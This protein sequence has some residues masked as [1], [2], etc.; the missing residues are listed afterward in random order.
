MNSTSNIASLLVRLSERLVV[1]HYAKCGEWVS[2]NRP[3][4][5]STALAQ[6]GQRGRVPKFSP[7]ASTLPT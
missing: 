2:P 3:N 6:A 7:L 5:T 1:P 4:Q